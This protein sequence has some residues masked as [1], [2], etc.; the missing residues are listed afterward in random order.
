MANIPIFNPTYSH[1]VQ[2]YY[3]HNGR[4][5]LISN[6]EYTASLLILLIKLNIYKKF[7]T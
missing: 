4:N 3:K 2:T 6:C 1:Q 5:Y 7:L